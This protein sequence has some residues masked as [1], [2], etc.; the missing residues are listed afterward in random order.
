MAT[1]L[2]PKYFVPIFLGVSQVLSKPELCSENFEGIRLCSLDA[3]Y[4]KSYP[5]DPR[6][7]SLKQTITLLDIFEFNADT[8][9]VTLS[10]RLK[11]FWKDTRIT[12]QSSNPN[13]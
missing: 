5:P 12:L 13:E 10:L 7:I 9:T 1:G 6:P 4:D 2:V 3:N 8:Q 11:T